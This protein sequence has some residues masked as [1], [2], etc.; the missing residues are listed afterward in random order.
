MESIEFG[1]IVRDTVTG[2]EGVV[3]ARAEYDTGYRSFQIEAVGTEGRPWSDWVEDN[4][5]KLVS[6][7]A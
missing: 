1:D 7:K 2:A 5:L 3:T 6:K 4:R